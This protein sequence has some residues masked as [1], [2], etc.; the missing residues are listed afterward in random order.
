MYNCY[1]FI[2]T[3]TDAK[4]LSKTQLVMIDQMQDVSTRGCLSTAYRV[5]GG[6]V[7]GGYS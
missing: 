4:F 2:D 3:Y 1:E 6:E 5:R 7:R